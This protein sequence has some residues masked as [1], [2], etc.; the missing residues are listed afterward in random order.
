MIYLSLS[1][2]SDTSTSLRYVHYVERASNEQATSK[3][4]VKPKQNL[5]LRYSIQ[6]PEANTF[7]AETI[8]GK[9]LYMLKTKGQ[10]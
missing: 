10:A 1:H 8:I 3:Q 2:L 9:S 7:T 6:Y 4:R 5:E